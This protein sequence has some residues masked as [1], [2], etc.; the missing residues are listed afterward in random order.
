MTTLSSRSAASASSSACHDRPSTTSPCLSM[1]P[2]CGSWSGSMPCTWRI[3][4]PVAGEWCST[5]TEK[6]S[7][8]AAIVSETSCGAWDYE[9][10][11]RSPAPRCRVN[12]RSAFP[13]WL[14][15][16]P[17]QF[18]IRS[19]RQILPTSHCGRDS[20]TWWRLWIYSPGMC[21]AESSPTALTRSSAWRPW[22][23]PW[24]VATS[25]RS[26][27]PIRAVNSPRQA[28]FNDLKQRRSRSAG[29]AV[30]A[31]TTTS[32]WRGCG[33]PSSTKRCTCEPTAIAGKRRS[34]WP[35]SSGGTAI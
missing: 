19:G 29:P 11:T 12:H 8:S 18:R 35:A 16:E 10:S 21:S 23:W 17:S 14:M 6:E 27:T 15:S 9:R 7:P 1:S 3:P 2:P 4:P 26:S 32:W 31:A 28:S 25:P 20:C 34:A 30:D 33:A 13:A 5:W 22:R 24:P